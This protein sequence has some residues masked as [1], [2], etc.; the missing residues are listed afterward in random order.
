MSPRA[1]AALRAVVYDGRTVSAVPR[2]ELSPGRGE[3]LV[4]PVRVG[5][6]PADLQV[7]ESCLKF[8]GV[9]GHEF[10][11]V[12]EKAA[13][14]A[15]APWV[16]K[17]VVGSPVVSC[18][19]CERCRAGLSAHCAD[20]RVLGLH[21][22]DGCWADR[23]AIP[24]SNLVEVPKSV[25]DDAALLSGVAGTA[26]HA[27]RATRLEGKTYV[28]IIGDNA[29]AL[30]A[31]QVFAKLNASVRVLGF[32]PARFSVCDRWRLKHRHADEVGRRQDQDVVFECSG[33]ARGAELA[34][35]LVRPRGRVLLAS[36]SPGVPRQALPDT[37]PVLDSVTVAVGEIEVVGI[38][39][40]SIRD[41]L[42][43]L[44]RGQ[45]DTSGLVTRRG[46]MFDPAAAFDLA[47]EPGCV[48]LSV[49]EPRR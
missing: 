7:A 33:T 28:S 16:G 49:E 29:L 1:V 40:G 39:R 18:G 9:L 20:R 6:T 26:L 22:R 2:P 37:G 30:I 35:R 4:R 45:I 32:E 12:V 47:R 14:G 34:T 41:G 23:F 17:R 11:G 46:V 27:A 19:V 43:A 3:V 25:G 10:V 15:G 48:R 36:P 42:D 31:V 8:R 38:G 21:D 24:A 13:D 44:A 5:V